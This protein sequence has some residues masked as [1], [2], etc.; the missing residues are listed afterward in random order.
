MSFNDSDLTEKFFPTE[1]TFRV[2]VKSVVPGTSQAG[3][4]MFTITY[5]GTG[6]FFAAEFKERVPVMD[7]T[8]F[9]WVNLFRA[10]GFTNEQMKAGLEPQD[11]LGKFLGLTR[12][13]LG[14]KTNSR[15]GQSYEDTQET[16]FALTPEEVKGLQ[17]GEPENILDE[18]QAP[19]GGSPDDFDGPNL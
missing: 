5:R 7:K 3:N 6:D 19:G 11:L 2:K 8:R 4:Q 10:A 1:G 17:S 14:Q 16:F 9:R 18:V 13:S 15:T 12:K